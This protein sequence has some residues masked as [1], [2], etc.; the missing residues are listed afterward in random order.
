MTV[1]AST[2]ARAHGF[3]PA[4]QFITFDCHKPG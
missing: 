4:Y 1:I 3:R 2:Q